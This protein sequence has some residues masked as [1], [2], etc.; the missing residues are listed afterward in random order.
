MCPSIAS[1]RNRLLGFVPKQDILT[2][3]TTKGSCIQG[4]RQYYRDS[5]T[6]PLCLPCGDQQSSFPPSGSSQLQ[7]EGRGFSP[8][9][10]T[11]SEY[12]M[13]LLPVQLVTVLSLNRSFG[14]GHAAVWLDGEISH[15]C[16]SVTWT[17]VT[18]SERAGAS[19]VTTCD[20]GPHGK[21]APLT[22]CTSV[23]V[24]S[25]EIMSSYCCLQ[26]NPRLKG[27]ATWLLLS[28]T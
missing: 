22:P 28:P 4:R 17:T 1:D 20:R 9:S 18:E 21:V 23:T 8:N 3:G 5:G 16:S 7:Q 14:L 12:R 2:L 24:P 6:L 27:E 25:Q 15:N 19:A 26:E 10:C 11:K 13:S